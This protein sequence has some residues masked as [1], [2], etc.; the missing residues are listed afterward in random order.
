MLRL[1]APRGSKPEPIAKASQRH[2]AL[3]RCLA[4]GM[5]PAE[6]SLATG[7]CA[8][9]I[10]ILQ[11]DE[12]FSDLVSQYQAEMGDAFRANAEQLSGLTNEA[13][14]ALRERLESSPEKIATKDLLEIAKLGADRSGH[15]PST[16][17]NTNVNLNL[18]ER[19]RQA[20][21]RV[22]EAD[23]VEVAAA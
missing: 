19:L 4:M 3:A 16:T 10:S 20:R 18:S 23:Y 6:A 8:S 1:S 13:L 15:G 5:K 21:Q 9:R 17:T 7:Y 12:T 11:Q 2:H 14:T 22:I